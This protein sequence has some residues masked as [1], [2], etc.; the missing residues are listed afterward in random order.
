MSAPSVDWRDR[1][2]WNWIS[3][4]RWQGGCNSCWAFGTAALYEAMVRIEQCVWCRRSEGD[5]RNGVGNRHLLL[6]VQPGSID[7]NQTN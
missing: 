6:V 3:S 7:C 2:G 1:F 5:I 4:V